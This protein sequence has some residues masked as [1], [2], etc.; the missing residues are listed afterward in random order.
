M[1]ANPKPFSPK[2]ILKRLRLHPSS[3]LREWW[4]SILWEWGKYPAYA[5][6]LLSQSD[7]KF[8]HY[9]A[10]YGMDLDH[11]SGGNCLVL[12]I[13]KNKYLRSGVDKKLRTVENKLNIDYWKR[14]VRES[15]SEGYSVLIADHFN[16]QYTDFP[17]LVFFQDIRS[18]EHV[19]VS[20]K[21][22]QVDEIAERMKV[23]FSVINNAILEGKPVLSEV[24]KLKDKE[25]F[26][27]SGA[28]AISSIRTI[29]GKTFETAMEAWIKV[30]ILK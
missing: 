7:K 21:G 16:I 2:E 27:K 12:V 14:L 6:I 9:L 3:T 18:P 5:F 19:I 26:Q 15:S 29:A 13:N 28:R 11:L 23:I 4:H 17:C 22:M 20:F 8:S 10:D 30:L 1:I 25:S 24:Q